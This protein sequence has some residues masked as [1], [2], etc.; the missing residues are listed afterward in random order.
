MQKPERPP[1]QQNLQELFQE[2]PITAFK[3]NKNVKEIITS[4]HTENRKVKNSIIPLE[5]E[6]TFHVHGGARTKC[7]NQVMTTN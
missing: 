1:N 3:R 7:Y 5:Q 4:T 2:H 6:N